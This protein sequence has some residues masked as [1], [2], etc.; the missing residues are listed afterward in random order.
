MPWCP[1]GLFAS[2]RTPF[3]PCAVVGLKTNSRQTDRTLRRD[4]F[5]ISQED[6]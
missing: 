4:S 3:P 5:A 6:A 1:S 2:T